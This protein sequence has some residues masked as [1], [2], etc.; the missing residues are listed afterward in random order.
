[1]VSLKLLFLCITLLSIFVSGQIHR[2]EEFPKTTLGNSH[3]FPLCGMGVGNLQHELIESQISHGIGDDMK[4]RLIDTAHASRNEGLIFD[5]I[6]QGLSSFTSDTDLKIHVITKVWYTHLGYE[7]TQISV[8]E[9]LQH[10]DSPNIRVHILIHWPR[11]R[12]DIQWMKCEEEE[13]RLPEYIKEAGPPPHLDKDNAFKE[14]WRALEDIF[15]GKIS[16]GENP[17]LIESIGVSNFDI[18]DLKELVNNSRITPHILQGNVWSYV[19]DPFLI[20]YCRKT[21]I[22]FQAYN[23]I[24]G[25]HDRHDV[26]P[27]AFSL[28]MLIAEELS[29]TSKHGYAPAHVILKWLIQNKVS[30]IPRTRQLG[31]LQE[32]SPLTLATMPDLVPSQEEKVRIAVAALLKGQDLDQPLATFI[33]KKDAG[34]LHLFWKSHD[35]NEIAIRN[36]LLPGEE[37]Q[38]ITYP[39]HVF[40]IYDHTRSQRKELMIGADF[41]ETQQFHI[42][43]L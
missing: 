38:T 7:R 4:Y 37:F 34:N 20:D 26:S 27:R 9:S 43:E 35:G 39:G 15:L 33:N 23:V 1:M 32:N 28:L 16:L 42:D 41:G 2:K 19:F 31:H 12:D 22:H 11:C 10:L 14:S 21:D 18:H 40:V 25:I 6:L 36:N 29:S 17:P 13:D 24:N 30:V 5:G 3:E 8:R